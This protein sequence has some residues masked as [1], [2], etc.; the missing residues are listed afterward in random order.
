[1]DLQL[2]LPALAVVLA[3]ALSG[4]GALRAYEKCGYA[5]CPGDAQISADVRAQLKRDP[6]L[7]PPNLIYVNTLDHVVYLSGEVDTDL[8]RA[9]AVS[10]ARTTPGAAKVVDIIGLEYNGR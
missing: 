6:A 2:R 8:Q 3:A 10:I 4:C 7:A 9:T 5:G 1:M